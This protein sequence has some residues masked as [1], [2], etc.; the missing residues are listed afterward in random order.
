MGFNGGQ[1][2]LFELR[3]FECRLF[4]ERISLLDDAPVLQMLEDN[5]LVAE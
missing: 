5:D 3:L 1:F 2:S 4:D